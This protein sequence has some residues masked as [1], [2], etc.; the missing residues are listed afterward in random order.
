MRISDWSSDVCSSDLLLNLLS[1]AM[2][3]TPSGG[4]GTVAAR[5]DGADLVI[6]VSDT[7]IGIP[8]AD[9]GRVIQPFE[10]VDNQLTRK[11][12]GTGLG[13]ALCKSLT[14]LQ[15]GGLSIEG[16]EGSGTPG[17]KRVV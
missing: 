10:Q 11:H 12:T 3:C 6:A 2:K 13:L 14:E 7:G 4:R 15:G 5:L 17:R 8:A 9:L 1:N 16:A